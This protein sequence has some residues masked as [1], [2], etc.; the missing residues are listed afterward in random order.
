VVSR[1]AL[2]VAELCVALLVASCTNVTG[3]APLAPSPGVR[4]ASTTPFNAQSFAL[5]F[6]AEIA[7]RVGSQC[8]YAG[9]RKLA[10]RLD[11]PTQASPGVWSFNGCVASEGNVFYD[12]TLL[13]LFP[14][15]EQLAFP[16][17]KQTSRDSE[18]KFTVE[19]RRQTTAG[20]VAR[21]Y[22]NYSPATQ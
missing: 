11:P 10:A 20:L 2:C 12:L 3:S 8:G 22:C 5:W 4:T 19:V 18:T 14:D 16:I 7:E 13:L 21:L 1:T 17:A 6:P 15:G 9:E